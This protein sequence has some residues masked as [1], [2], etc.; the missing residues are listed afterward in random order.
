MWR[1]LQTRQSTKAN[2][3]YSRD[4]SFLS[5]TISSCSA[6]YANNENKS[7]LLNGRTSTAIRSEWNEIINIILEDSRGRRRVLDKI[8][9]ISPPSS[10]LYRSERRIVLLCAEIPRSLLL[11]S[12]RSDSC[13]K[14]SWQIARAGVK[15]AP[16]SLMNLSRQI[17][18][19]DWWRR[20][21]IIS[22]LNYV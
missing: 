1:S 7:V 6:V 18:F 17:K 21:Q 22:V 3:E 8:A 4:D 12:E 9:I 13:K 20:Q 14:A 15:K 11:A 2:P 16:P 5:A 10:D 19:Q